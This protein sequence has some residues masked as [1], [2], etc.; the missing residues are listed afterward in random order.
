[1]HG[2]HGG[3][4]GHFFHAPW[5]DSDELRRFLVA[6]YNDGAR[7]LSGP[8]LSGHLHFFEWQ[9]RCA[10]SLGN[11][12]MVRRRWSRGA[13]SGRFDRF[14]PMR[15]LVEL[16]LL[17]LRLVVGPRLF[18]SPFRSDLWAARSTSETR[19]VTRLVAKLPTVFG[20]ERDAGSWYNER[21]LNGEIRRSPLEISVRRRVACRFGWMQLAP[22]DA[23]ARLLGISSGGTK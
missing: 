4:F 20:C 9:G 13:W 10:F 22:N 21:P 5:S 16:V 18:P 7:I 1:M 17:K 15:R 3:R 8:L 11:L 23:L 2:H 14:S 6:G 19:F 12:V